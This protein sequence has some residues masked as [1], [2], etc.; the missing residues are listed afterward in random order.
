[1]TIQEAAAVGAGVLVVWLVGYF[2]VRLVARKWEQ[3]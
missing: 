2:L 3:R 1:M